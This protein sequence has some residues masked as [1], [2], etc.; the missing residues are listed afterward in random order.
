M[1]NLSGMFDKAKDAALAAKDKAQQAV[2]DTPDS[3]RGGLDKVE[4]F[5]NDKTG[6]KYAD[7]LHQGRGN[8]DK[9]LGVPGDTKDAFRQEAN[10]PHTPDPVRADPI[11]APAP[12]DTPSPIDDDIAR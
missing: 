6:G 2:R 5:V 10:K 3:V 12:I 9:A 7:R 11:D 4:G 8:L 1:V